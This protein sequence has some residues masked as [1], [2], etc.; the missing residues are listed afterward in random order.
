MVLSIN[1]H[2]KTEVKKTAV[3]PKCKSELDNRVPRGFFVKK[4]LFFLP[5]KRY[6]C[7]KC[8]RKRYILR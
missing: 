5:L 6:M 7:Y 3:C 1:Q 2:E 4:V 8:Q